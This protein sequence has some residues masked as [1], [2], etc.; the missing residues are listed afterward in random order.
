M[1]IRH[2]GYIRQIGDPN[3]NVLYSVKGKEKN[4]FGDRITDKRGNVK[5]INVDSDIM[6]SL[7]SRTMGYS[8]KTVDYSIM[9]VTGKDKEKIDK[10]IL[11][12]L[13]LLP[14]YSKFDKQVKEWSEAMQEDVAK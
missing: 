10:D 9:D 11:L 4:D 12:S 5:S 8:D 3:N 6:N 2:E 7:V 13:R 14:S 1:V